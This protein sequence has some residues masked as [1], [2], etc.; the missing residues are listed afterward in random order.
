MHPTGI[1][2]DENPNTPFALFKVL[3][4]VV[5]KLITEEKEMGSIYA[6][7]PEGKRENLDNRRSK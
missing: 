5:E 7:I 4:F 3:N 6:L 1:D 2:L